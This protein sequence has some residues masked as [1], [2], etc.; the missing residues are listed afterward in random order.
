MGLASR[1]RSLS[2]L[3]LL[4]V[5]S[6]GNVA[7]YPAPPTP[8]AARAAFERFRGLTGSWRSVSTKGWDETTT[9]EV[10]GRGSVV[11]STT[12]FGDAARKMV[13]MFYLD[14]DRLVATHYC[15]ARNQP[16][17]VA[18]EISDDGRHVVFRF[19]GGGNLPDR[20]RGH[21][22]Q[23]VYRF[24]HPDRVRSRWSWYQEGEER[25]L[26]DIETTRS[27]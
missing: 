16:H 21:M 7:A 17:L 1:H 23:A 5:M 25:W 15:E 18:E 22:D 10:I 26:E 13:T 19:A 8:E 14:G 4:A 24:P 11:M 3:A 20:N 2:A 9:Y 6:A 27:R 12:T